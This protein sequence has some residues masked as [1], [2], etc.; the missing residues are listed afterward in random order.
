MI[1]LQPPRVLDDRHR[2]LVLEMHFQ[3]KSVG[4]LSSWA[5]PMGF[6]R[7]RLLGGWEIL[8]N[9][10]KAQVGATALLP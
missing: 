7:Q 5:H 10:T 1:L 2:D 8:S 4:T 6:A 9:V 3:L